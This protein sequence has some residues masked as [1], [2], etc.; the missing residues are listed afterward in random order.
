MT[1]T[2]VASAMKVGDP[3]T[4]SDGGPMH[5]ATAPIDAAG[6]MPAI[7]LSH[8][9]SRITPPTWGTGPSS[10][11]HICIDVSIAQGNGM[12]AIYHKATTIRYSGF[13]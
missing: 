8:V 2:G 10:I 6:R 13:L 3:S 1:A 7:T 4:T 5:I 11:G 9:V 12:P